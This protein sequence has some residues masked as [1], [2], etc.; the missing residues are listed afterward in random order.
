LP[1]SDPDVEDEPRAPEEEERFFGYTLRPGKEDERDEEDCD[2]EDAEDPST[3]PGPDEG[4]HIRREVIEER[5]RPP[6]RNG[7]NGEKRSIAKKNA[8]KEKVHPFRT[9]G[10]SDMERN[11]ATTS[12]PTVVAPHKKAG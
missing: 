4:I 7:E 3:D 9:S 2:D 12:P 1:P 10:S 11:M 6:R 8:M 5:H